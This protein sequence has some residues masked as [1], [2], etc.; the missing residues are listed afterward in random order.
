MGKL[1]M[2][3]ALTLINIA[4]ASAMI[5]N[6]YDEIQQY[7]AEQAQIEQPVIRSSDTNQGNS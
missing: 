7:Q 4:I 2:L 1:Q 6:D 3:T 5:S